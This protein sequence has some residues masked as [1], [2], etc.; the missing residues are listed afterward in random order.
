MKKHWKR[1]AMERVKICLHYG[2][3]VI[4]ETIENML[5]KE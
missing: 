5:K 3:Q 1:I 4:V 2:M